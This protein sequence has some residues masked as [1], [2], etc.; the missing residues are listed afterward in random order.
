MHIFYW[1]ISVTSWVNVAMQNSWLS[2]ITGYVFLCRCGFSPVCDNI[3]FLIFQDQLPTLCVIPVSHKF[4]STLILAA[5]GW[6]VWEHFG[7]KCV[8]VGVGD[9]YE[10]HAKLIYVQLATFGHE[11]LVSAAWTNCVM[12]PSAVIWKRKKEKG[13]GGRNFYPW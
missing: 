12:W 6:I 1:N 7:P 4:G 9:R 10:E 11:E 8:P 13:G 3:L 2:S 5:A